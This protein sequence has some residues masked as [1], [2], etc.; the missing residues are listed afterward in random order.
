MVSLFQDTILL[1]LA[2]F[3]R[4][5]CSQQTDSSI[6]FKELKNISYLLSLLM[7]RSASHLTHLWMH[8]QHLQNKSFSHTLKF[9]STLQ[10]KPLWRC[11]RHQNH[12]NML[13]WFK[14]LFQSSY[15]S[16]LEQYI[17]SKYP[18]HTGDV[19]RLTLEYHRKVNA[20]WI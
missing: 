18:Q 15:G 16:R 8:K 12:F 13:S 14:S 20:S 9:Q 7:K 10:T 1:T 6:P 11:K 17:I 2:K 19:E 3:R 4:K 5:L